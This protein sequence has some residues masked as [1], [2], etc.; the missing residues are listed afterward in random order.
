MTPADSAQ[1]D[2]AP[3]VQPAD[4]LLC[5][6]EDIAAASRSM[7]GAAQRGDWDAVAAIE[8]RC[9]HLIA[10]LRGLALTQRLGAPEQRRRM[11]LLRAILQDDA[12]IR[13]RA[14]PWLRDLESILAAPQPRA[15]RRA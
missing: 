2:V 14:E 15:R 4:H 11:A 7:L 6:Y 3:K 1:P 5:C 13:V 8:S 12:Q 10:R 9:R